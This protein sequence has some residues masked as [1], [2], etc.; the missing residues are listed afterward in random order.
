LP[1]P[2]PR[3]AG[4]LGTQWQGDWSLAR[5][6]DSVGSCV[7]AVTAA[8]PKWQTHIRLLVNDVRRCCI[9]LVAK[10]RFTIL[11]FSKIVGP[12]GHFQRQLEMQFMD[13]HDFGDLPRTTQQQAANVSLTFLS[14]QSSVALDLAD[15]RCC[16][17]GVDKQTARISPSI[18]S[19]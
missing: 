11:Q 6:Q 7:T 10:T 9:I 17:I 3:P 5:S 8:E 16:R 19:E 2:R 4:G 14:M 18:M 12:A 15:I 13:P 1:R